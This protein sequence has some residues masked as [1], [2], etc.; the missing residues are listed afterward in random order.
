MFLETLQRVV[1]ISAMSQISRAGDFT[2][3]EPVI[4]VQGTGGSNRFSK[5]KN[6]F[7][8]GNN[9]IK[10]CNL[11]LYAPYF[12]FNDLKKF[13]FHKYMTKILAKARHV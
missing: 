9:Y 5:W 10:I 7:L 2:G 12:F 6:R 1:D 4:P 8:K 3:L 11:N 13:W